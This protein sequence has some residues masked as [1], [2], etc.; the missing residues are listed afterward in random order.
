MLSDADFTFVAREVKARSGAVMP[1]EA[2]ALAETRLIPLSRREGFS[3]VAELIQIAR[4]KGD[5]KLWGAIAEA[6]IQTDTRFFR[7]RD[8][9]AE[10]R[11]QILPDLAARAGRPL[12]IWSAGC[13]TGQ[14]PYSIAMLVEDLRDQGFPGAEIVATDISERVL[15][16]ARSGLY[17]QFEVQRGL[18]IRKLIAHFE[19]AG[20]L[21]RISDRMRAAV[22]FESY[23][24]LHAGEMMG[25]FDLALCRNVIS[26]FDD[27]TKASVLEQVS[28]TLAPGGVLMLGQH[29]D[30]GEPGARFARS[31]A[32]F[33]L[34]HGAARAA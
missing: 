27:A 29:E 25:P 30:I 23:N 9:F 13:S 3:S 26:I 34:A 31:G 2:N 24:L 10:L 17:T 1:R 4:V 12:R 15:D 20:D 19:K 14:E 6:L 28:Q 16:K 5:G 32:G 7:D 33:K 18:P 22:R 21:W 8:V 11:D